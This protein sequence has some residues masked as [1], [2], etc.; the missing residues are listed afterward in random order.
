M[1]RT[2]RG[3]VRLPRSAQRATL[4]VVVCVRGGRGQDV[5]DMH[6]GQA[7]EGSVTSDAR[8]VTGVGMDA[9]CWAAA[10]EVCR[11]A[12]VRDGQVW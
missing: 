9:A 11:Y 4:A 2:E 3:E 12:R 5:S 1:G 8:A 6:S 7:F 10:V